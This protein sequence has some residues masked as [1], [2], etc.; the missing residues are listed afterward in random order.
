MKEDF[1]HYVWRYQKFNKI[2]LETTDGGLV[3]TIKT[4]FAHHNS[5]PDFQHAKILVDEMEWNGAVEI[6]IKSSDWNR[7]HHHHDPNYENVVLH[8]VWQNDKPIQHP[9]GSKIPTIELKDRV[10]YTLIEKFEKLQNS[11]D[12]IPCAGHWFE[13]SDLHKS[14]MLEKVLVER[15]HRKSEK[16]KTHFFGT[17]NWDQA[18]YFMLL[19]AM[20]FK[21]NQHPFEHLAEILPY[22]LIKK[23]RANVFQLEA[24]LFGCSGFLNSS[25]EDSYPNQLKK[26]WEFLKHKHH[27]TLGSP[28]NVHEWRF[29]RLRPANFPTI[30]LAELAQILHIFPSIFDSFVIDL[31]LKSIQKRMKVKVSDY[32]LNHYQFDKESKFRKKQLGENSIKTLIINCLPPLL[33]L[34]AN[35][36]GE[37]K[38]MDKAIQLLNGIKAEKNYITKKFSDLG[39]EITSA[40]D[41]QAMIQLHNDYCQPKKCLDCSIGLSILKA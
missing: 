7:H 16:A 5:G 27:A 36:V 32:W 12:E 23:Y 8:V 9:D 31:N 19:S 20:G 15:L 22:S 11:Q 39:E 41:S 25:F 18:S 28:M 29:L 26:E 30:R 10:D 21:V 17:Q 6:H 14:E 38:Y 4:G 40:F 34:Y 24:L 37:E 3:K 2:D 33:A 13:V 1:L 35:S